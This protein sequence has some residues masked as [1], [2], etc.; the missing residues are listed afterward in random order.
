MLDGI[1]SRYGVL[2][3]T[4]MGIPT[5]TGEALL[6]NIKVMAMALEAQ[7]EG[8]TLTDDI[9]RKMARYPPEVKRELR[10]QGFWR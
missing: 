7:G 9:K 4:Q 6:F 3:S 2:P 10:R 5:G 1:G 8:G